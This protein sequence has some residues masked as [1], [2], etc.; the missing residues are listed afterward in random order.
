MVDVS[1]AIISV[2]EKRARRI[3]V[4]DQPGLHETLSKEVGAGRRGEGGRDGGRKIISLPLT[5]SMWIPVYFGTLSLMCLLSQGSRS[6]L[7]FGYS[8]SS[9]SEKLSYIVI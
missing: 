8:V 7:E 3:R 1:I 6:F 9:I 2:L 4:Q 5:L